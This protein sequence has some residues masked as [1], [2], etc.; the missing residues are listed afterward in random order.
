[1]VIDGSP[2]FSCG[3]IVRLIENRI[4]QQMRVKPTKFEDVF[5]TTSGE[6]YPVSLCIHDLPDAFWYVVAGSWS[7][8]TRNA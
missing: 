4:F 1:M 8:L 3:R 7:G 2:L 6:M 5:A